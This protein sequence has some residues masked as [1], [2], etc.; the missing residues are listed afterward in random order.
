MKKMIL[1]LPFFVF[2]ICIYAQEK[3][4]SKTKFIIGLA[5]PELFHAGIAYRI[6]NT[7]LISLSAGV[8][9]TSGSLWPSINLEHRLYFR[10]NSSRS[11]QKIF[12]FRQGTTFFTSARS[13]QQ[14]TL[15]LTVGKDIVFKNRNSGFTIDAGVFYLP[16]SDQS[17][18]ILIRS[19]NLWPALRFQFY[20]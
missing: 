11:N 3:P 17:S 16:E 14:F 19:L 8:G 6:S 2:T 13:P 7:N 18:I 20:F 9:P 4:I 1:A 15:N 5:A 12:F 10:R